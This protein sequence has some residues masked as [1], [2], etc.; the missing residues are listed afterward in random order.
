MKIQY[1]FFS[2]LLAFF[3]GMPVWGQDD[4]DAT[5]LAE[6]STPCHAIEDG[7]EAEVAEITGVEPGRDDGG[8]ATTQ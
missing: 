4:A 1:Y 3:W 6:T 2:L 8:G 7:R 5:V